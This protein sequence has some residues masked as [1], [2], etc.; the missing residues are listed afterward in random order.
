MQDEAKLFQIS[1]IYKNCCHAYLLAG[2]SACS[3]DSRPRDW[4]RLGP[5]LLV[6]VS[7]IISRDSRDCRQLYLLV[8]DLLK[9]LNATSI[10]EDFAASQIYLD[11]KFNILRRPQNFAKSP[12]YFCL[13]CIQTKVSWRFHKIFWPS[14]NTWTLPNFKGSLEWMGRH[15]CHFRPSWL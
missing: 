12:P 13:Q 8:L 9:A 11:L 15:R 4:S 3:R 1:T 14:Q 5:I 7:P 10:R 2:D 6:S